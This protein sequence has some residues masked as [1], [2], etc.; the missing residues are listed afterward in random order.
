[1]SILQNFNP[2]VEYVDVAIKNNDYTDKKQ[3]S[4]KTKDS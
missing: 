3:Y 4:A 2:I 1:M